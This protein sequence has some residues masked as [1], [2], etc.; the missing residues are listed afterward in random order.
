MHHQ[1]LDIFSGFKRSSEVQKFVDESQVT[2]LP[3]QTELLNFGSPINVVPFVLDGAIKVMRDDREGHGLYL[4]HIQPGESCAMTLSST[5]S[6]ERSQIK[7]V[8][9]EKTTLL[10]V[11]VSQIHR[12]YE[13]DPVFRDFV[14]S[15]FKQR[16]EELLSTLDQVAF[17]QI[18]KRLNQLL[19]D[20]SQALERNILHV[21]HQELA[22]ELNSSREVISRL[23]KQMEKNGMVELGRNRIKIIELM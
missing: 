22:D 6:R 13:Q 5:L 1:F 15:T 8:T 10:A 3:E 4:Y 2:E 21:T 19:R 14:L 11:P 18:D 12:W 17:Q 20:R 16:F 7:A 23:L 9:L